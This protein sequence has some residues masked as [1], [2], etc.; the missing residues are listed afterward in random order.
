MFFAT[1]KLVNIFLKT[2]NKKYE[3]ENEDNMGPLME[4][5]G[6]GKT[7]WQVWPKLGHLFNLKKE[8]AFSFSWLSC[9]FTKMCV[10]CDRI[11]TRWRNKL[12]VFVN[13]RSVLTSTVDYKEMKKL[14]L[15]SLV[16]AFP[17]SLLRSFRN[18]FRHSHIIRE[19]WIFMYKQSVNIWETHWLRLC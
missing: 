10:Q 16:R 5:L 17:F 3:P 1:L 2:S 15:Y 12:S 19:S 18:K 8:K 14:H 9:A 13:I 6:F 4:F 11:W 7:I